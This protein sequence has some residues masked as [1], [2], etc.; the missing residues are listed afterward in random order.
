[1]RSRGWE[2]GL[3][4]SNDPR[5][6]DIVLEVT[7]RDAATLSVL[8]V[9]GAVDVARCYRLSS[10]INDALAAAPARLVI[11]LRAVEFVD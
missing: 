5:T 11:D 4:T 8:V 9:R 1:V 6:G 3:T 10:A 7:R 2:R